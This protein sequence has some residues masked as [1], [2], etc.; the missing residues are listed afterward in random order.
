MENTVEFP[1]TSWNDG[2]KQYVNRT[3]RFCLVRPT[4]EET[5]ETNGQQEQK[6]SSFS[7][8]LRLAY[9]DANGTDDED[10][11]W[12]HDTSHLQQR[13]VADSN[14]LTQSHDNVTESKSQEEESVDHSNHSE[15]PVVQ[16]EGL[17][18]EEFL[19][20]QPDIANDESSNSSASEQNGKN[21]SN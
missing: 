16:Q 6:E 2:F 13:N 21:Q 17:S 9:K 7:R 19:L 4:G 1:A 14:H 3:Q 15:S 10:D 5:E 8:A 18:Q 12:L 11:E 20:G